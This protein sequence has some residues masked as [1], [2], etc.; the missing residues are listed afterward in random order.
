[1]ALQPDQKTALA[2]FTVAAKSIIF[3]A[4]RFKPLLE[5]MDTKTG[6]IQAV[7]S[8]M[9]GIE[10]KKPIPQNIAMLLAINIYVLLVDMAQ[11]ATDMKAD[12]GIVQGVIA[13]LMKSTLQS[14]GK[15]KRAKPQQPALQPQA[16]AAPQPTAAPAGLINQGV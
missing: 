12:K 15:T 2:Q 13:E 14:H 10:Q 3:N 8:V 1:M 4:E 6:A 5:L 9:G 16:P 11:D 7:H